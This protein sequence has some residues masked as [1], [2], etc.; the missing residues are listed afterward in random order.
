MDER[1]VHKAWNDTMKGGSLE[2]EQFS[3]SSNA[4][5]KEKGNGFFS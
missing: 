3:R 2:K 4:N 5:K 1:H